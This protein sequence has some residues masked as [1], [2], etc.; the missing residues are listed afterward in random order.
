MGV[1]KFR[2]HLVIEFAEEGIDL[3]IATRDMLDRYKIQQGLESER[4]RSEARQKGDKSGAVVGGAIEEAAEVGGDEKGCVGEEKRHVD[5]SLVGDGNEGDGEA[6]VVAPAAEGGVGP[7][8]GPG[9]EGGVQEGEEAESR[10]VGDEPVVAET[11]AEAAAAEEAARAM[12]VQGGGGDGEGGRGERSGDEDGVGEGE[13]DVRQ[14]GK[15][16]F[17][18]FIRSGCGAECNLP[19]TVV[20]KVKG[21]VRV[22]WVLDECVGNCRYG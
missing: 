18:R 5:S 22:P 17:E 7:E 12:G 11:S 3:L 4:K 9:G 14:T 15:G 20:T 19:G 21:Q 1:E 10:D 13:F 2:Q 16:I 8:A 6:A